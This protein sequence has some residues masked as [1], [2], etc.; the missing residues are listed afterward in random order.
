MADWNR[1]TEQSHPSSDKLWLVSA[2][3]RGGHDRRVIRLHNIYCSEREAR[4]DW[5]RLT[6]E[7][8]NRQYGRPLDFDAGFARLPLRVFKEDTDATS[9]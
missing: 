4:A 2:E 6:P 7:N 9:D 8:H 1:V 3:W 5:E